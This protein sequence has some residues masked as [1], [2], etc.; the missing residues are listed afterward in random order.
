VAA[1]AHD[2]TEIAARERAKNGRVENRRFTPR[3]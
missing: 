2:D 3:S 1:A